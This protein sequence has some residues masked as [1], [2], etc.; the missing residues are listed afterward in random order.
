MYIYNKIIKYEV[1][2]RPFPR[3]SNLLDVKVRLA[4]GRRAR[5]SVRMMSS[6]PAPSAR[7]SGFF[8]ESVVLLVRYGVVSMIPILSG[9]EGRY[10]GGRF[11]SACERLTGCRRVFSVPLSQSSP[12]LT[13]EETSV[14]P[15]SHASGRRGSHEPDHQRLQFTCGNQQTGNAAARTSP[16]R[17]ERG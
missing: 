1:L 12:R 3:H 7:T 5:K 9:G 16:E 11:R 6:R 15:V 14:G 10:R 8:W 17:V 13:A 4:R 2:F